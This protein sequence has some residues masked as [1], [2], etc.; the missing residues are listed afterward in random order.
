MFRAF[1]S[2]RRKSSHLAMAIALAGGA[3]LG[4]AAF[5]PAA[6]AQQVSQ[7]FFEAYE[8]V[9]ALTEGE[10]PNYEGAR[11]QL[12]SVY[13][14]ITNENDRMAA[15]NLT[16]MVGNGLNDGA[17]QRR[18]LEMMLESGLVAPEQIGQFNFFVA[19]LAYN[20]QDYAAA[21]E[22]VA[23]AQ[24]GGYV[25]SDA[26][27]LNDPEYIILQSYFAEDASA[28]GL[29][30][31]TDL[32]NTRMAAGETVPER[33]LLRGLQEAYDMD[34]AAEAVDV[35]E[36]LLKAYPSEQNWIN[37]L[38]VIGALVEFEPAARVDLL[39][40]MRLT[41]SLT[42]RQEYV[43]YIEDLDPR[44]MGNEVLAVLQLG[45]ENE[46]FTSDDGYYTE[47]LGIATPRAETDRNSVARYVSE[48]EA[49]DAVD[50]MSTADVMM[51]LEDYAQAERFY[52][53]A[54][55]RGADANM[56]HLRLGIAQAKQ[57]NHAAAI[58]TLGMVEGPRATIAR[59]W[60]VY[61]QIQSGM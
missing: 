56:A 2:A 20:M 3:V 7:E 50:A 33:Y 48:A 6:E 34:L 27:P 30:Y 40:L 19:S 22:A 37:S 42:Q 31:L 53:V 54:A 11:S 12:E 29:A 32:A 26:D 49:G 55:E 38:Q 8:P 61:S 43:R 44:I 36:M 24:A 23:A 47:V 39:R 15:G 35:S 4:T 41:G 59:M 58:E 16:L 9:A 51:S 57:G 13:A 18:G 52:Q 17:L 25:D 46:V 60:S 5:A 21:R 28:Q 14:A 1:R 10:A 45:L